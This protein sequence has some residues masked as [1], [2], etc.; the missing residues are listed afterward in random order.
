M[1][2]V[3]SVALSPSQLV[4]AL[5]PVE[6]AHRPGE[7]VKD[8]IESL[9]IALI[10][11]FVFR[12]FIIEAFIIPTG[13]MA[14]T[15]YGAHATVVCEDCGTEFAYGLKDLDDHRDMQQVNSHS[16]A[17]C[18]NCQHAMTN[19]RVTDERRNPEKG[20]RIL[21]LKWPF[22]LGIDA[23]G[24]QRWDV[25]VFKDPADGVTNFI[26]RLAGLPNEV[27]MILDGD[28]Y[29]APTSTLTP[30]TLQAFEE[31]HEQKFEFQANSRRIGRLK[32]LPAFVYEELET[33][34]RITRKAPEAQAA[35]W[36]VLYDHDHPP[37]EHDER[38]Q[39]FWHRASANDSGWETESRR[40]RFTSKG[41]PA[42]FIE[43][44]GKDIRA[45][46]AYNV[47]SQSL[48]PPVSDLRTR[49]GWTPADSS[50]V[51]RVRLEKLGR[52]FWGSV[53]ADGRVA[54][55]ESTEPPT[56]SDQPLVSRAI[57]PIAPGK[58][59]AVVFQNV[60]YRVAL[61]IGDEEMLHTA[62]EP[63]SPGYY[64]P[65]IR[66]L[67]DMMSRGRSAW[68]TYRPNGGAIPP[69][70]YAEG[71]DCELSHLVVERDTHYYLEESS[72]R[73]PEIPWGPVEGWAG[74]NS[75]ILLRGH[76]YFMLGDN[77]S[78]SKD[79]R[80]WDVIGPHLKDRGRDFQ[81]GTVPRDQLIGKAFYVYWPYGHRLE[82]LPIPGLNRVGIIPDVGRMRW[83]R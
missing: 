29:A 65:D 53:H 19:L 20:D 6:A 46:N 48:P 81:L 1:D 60:D 71:G 33:K 4:A 47:F 57:A 56:E 18:P 40:V 82:W 61:W 37:R 21:V 35:L 11:A 52:A 58:T 32:S 15:L 69:R 44:S 78:A 5:P 14:P 34:L 22:D 54:I 83:I 76:E 3:V 30:E 25:V 39:P 51:V 73:L 38:R 68:R 49:F 77:T 80:L 27:I 74:Y 72:H 17:I 66:M 42:D 28:L 75:P 9:L 16:K 67:R 10:L 2:R 12:A 55:H 50:S 7:S 63:A 70:V 43:L 62:D 79:S 41:G 26:K 13:S 31:L 8:T 45:S 59:V 23:L 24:P 36:R 64:G